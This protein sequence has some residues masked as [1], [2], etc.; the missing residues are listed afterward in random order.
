M[1]L[2][3]LRYF[4]ATAEEENVTRAAARLRVAQPSLSRQIRDLEEMLNLSLFERSAKTLRL[5][6]AGKSFLI[7]SRAVLSRVDDALQVARTLAGG[8]R[9]EIDVGYAPSLTVELLPR[10]LRLFHDSNPDVQV[11]L[12][13]LSTEEMCAGLLDGTLQV[14]L[15]VQAAGKAMK[16]I[17]FE[18][19]RK[20]PICVAV[21]PSHPMAQARKVGLKQVSQERLIVYS[22]S[23]YPEYHTWFH[24]LFAKAGLSP[25]VAEEYDSSTSLIAS[26]EAGR[27]V[28][29]VQQGFECLAGPRLTVRPLSSVAPPFT[30]GIA[31]LKKNTSPMVQSFLTAARTLA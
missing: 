18:P 11:S 10:A 21:H 1:E 9:K 29:L 5:T 13:D 30:V 19:L 28:A 14:A 26:V 3:H 4:V 15:M 17:S 16:G 22:R 24:A 27:G 2:R 23:G 25:Q 12:H 6:A 20:F 7:E 31:C 8:Q